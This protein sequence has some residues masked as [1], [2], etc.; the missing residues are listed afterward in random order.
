MLWKKEQK[1][2]VQVYSI[3]VTVETICICYTF[4]LILNTTETTYVLLWRL[5]LVI[6][7]MYVYIIIILEHTVTARLQGTPCWIESAPMEKW[8]AINLLR[9]K[10]VNLSSG[11]PSLRLLQIWNFTT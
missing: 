9:N 7:Y 4:L 8:L 2:W 5:L 3:L 6:L 1:V 10:F 11:T